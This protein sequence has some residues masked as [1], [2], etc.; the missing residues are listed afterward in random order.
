L[1]RGDA[2]PSRGRAGRRRPER[3][4]FLAQEPPALSCSLDLGDRAGSLL[5]GG[6]GAATFPA[7]PQH[8]VEDGA[9]R[10]REEEHGLPCLAVESVTLLGR[11]ESAAEVAAGYCTGT[12]LRSEI[13]ARGDLAATTAVV[14]EEIEAR[15]GTGEVK[16]MMTAHV[17][18]A[19]PA[20]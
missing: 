14:A 9:D 7:G 17:F 13:E 6:V 10:P 20:A 2:P 16:G 8:R 18:E 5:L 11:A 3:G 1:T 19:T 12:P 4:R 15:L